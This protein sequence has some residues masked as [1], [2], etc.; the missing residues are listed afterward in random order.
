MTRSAEAG[1][2]EGGEQPR[3]PKW[4]L[5]IALLM[6]TIGLVA[7]DIAVVQAVWDGSGPSPGYL[8]MVLPMA[9]GLILALPRL[10][11]AGVVRNFWS[12]FEIVGWSMILI[13]GVM[14]GYF[15][16]A[17]FYPYLK[18]K[19]LLPSPEDSPAHLAFGFG[20]CIASSLPLQ[21]LVAWLGGW[22]ASF[23]ARYKVT[24]ERR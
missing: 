18:L 23:T 14:D 8:S 21:I 17:L 24:I 10:R 4:K 13:L 16:D 7:A 15:K 12:G 9:D 19:N 5:S 11:R 6:T 20:I 22:L 2:R 3:R 1:D